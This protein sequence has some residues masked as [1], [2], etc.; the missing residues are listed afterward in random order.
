MGVN[1]SNLQSDVYL[2]YGPIDVLERPAFQPWASLFQ[3]SP[4]NAELLIRNALLF[5]RPAVI[6]D[7]HPQNLR[8]GL[9]LLHSL[10]PMTFVVVVGHG[11]RD[12][13]LAQ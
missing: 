13:S 11:E 1:L 9:D 8:S 7:V 6:T 5:V 4:G 3:H 12:V 2:V 10:D